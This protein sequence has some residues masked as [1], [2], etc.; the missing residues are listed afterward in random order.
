MR[1]PAVEQSLLGEPD[2]AMREVAFKLRADLFGGR[3]DPVLLL[4]VDDASLRDPAYSPTPV[5]QPPQGMTPRKLIADL[6]AYAKSAPPGRGADVVLVDVDIGSPGADADSVLRLRQALTD[7]GRDRHAPL[8]VL[9]REA[10]DPSMVGLQG[11]N[12]VL[13]TTPY[14]DLVASAPNIFWGST[15]ML[16]DNDNVVREWLPFRCV[17]SGGQVQPLFNSAL[18]AYGAQVGD[19][20]PPGSPAKRW[21]DAAPRACG[22]KPPRELTHGEPIDFHISLR[23]PDQSWPPVRD[24]WPGQR[25][26]GGRPPTLM[27]VSAAPVAQAGVNASPDIL[28]RRIVIIGGTNHVSLDFQQTPLDF[29]PGAIVLANAARGLQLTDGGLRPVPFPIQAAALLAFSILLT[30]SFEVTERARA[31][32]KRRRKNARSSIEQVALASA[33]P[34]VLNATLGVGAHYAGAA[35]LIWVLSFGY[36]GF[37]SSPVFGAAL[38]ATILDFIDDDD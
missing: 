7:W 16:A 14:D 31:A 30:A 5:G 24:G 21:I 17:E 25:T 2:R 10:F 12:P 33:N 26:C 37:L 9:A 8:L 4:D 20:I 19:K 11:S 35:L 27:M 34:V 3:A 1:H 23:N 29:M 22:A 36:W 6:L 15:R 28:C 18:L 32:Y 38:A 13:P